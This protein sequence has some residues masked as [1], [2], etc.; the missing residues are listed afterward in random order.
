MQFDQ[1]QTVIHPQHGPAVVTG[2]MSRTIKGNVIDYIEL[3][4]CETGLAVS[5]PLSK[6]DDV[7]I[8]AVAG[9][10]MLAEIVGVLTAPTGA[11]ETQWARR[12]KAQRMEAATGDPLRIAAVVRDLIRRR[13]ERGMSLAERDLLREASAPLLAEIALATDASEEKAK[14]V[15]FKLVMEG[16]AEVLAH[17]DDLEVTAA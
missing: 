15:L 3:T 16:D 4:V 8:R 10:S 5:I 2:T 13:E 6:C 12:Y 9:S 11:I 17:V 1:G 7:G 14:L